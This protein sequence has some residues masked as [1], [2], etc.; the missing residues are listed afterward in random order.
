MRYELSFEA[1]PFHWHEESEELEGP[2][3]SDRGPAENLFKAYESDCKG[4][5]LLKQLT[6][7]KPH[8][9]DTTATKRVHELPDLYK[10]LAELE[11]DLKSHAITEDDYRNER[12]KLLRSFGYPPGY[13]LS[14]L[15]TELARAKCQQTMKFLRDFTPCHGLEV[16][17]PETIAR[18]VAAHYLRTELGLSLDPQKINS[19]GF[20]RT[21]WCDVF[22]PRGITIRVSFVKVP[23]ILTA[24][25]VA[26]KLG[27]K[28]EY[29]Y[30]CA[31]K[32]GRSVTLGPPPQIY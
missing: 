18:Q 32:F 11:R 30:N 1:E 22:Y 24:V 5:D 23:H 27:P 28:R 7:V 19:R 31:G 8:P 26:P 21:S 4:V 20:G 17:E 16:E 25:Q 2:I 15:K 13:G 12:A 10:K 14:D 9:F 6:K 29:G 3:F